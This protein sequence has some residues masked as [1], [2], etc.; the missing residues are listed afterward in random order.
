[1]C[2]KLL[3]AQ[4]R[5]GKKNSKF[6]CI[7]LIKFVLFRFYL[8]KMVECYSETLGI[9]LGQLGVDTE[10]YG[11]SYCNIVRDFQQHILYGFFIGVLIAMANTSPGTVH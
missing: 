8:I 10:S 11:V 2:K 5:V 4:L 3:H 7:E 6:I 1:L 9:T